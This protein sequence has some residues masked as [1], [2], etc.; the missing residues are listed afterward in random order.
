MSSSEDPNKGKPPKP[1]D[2]PDLGLDSSNTQGSAGFDQQHNPDPTQ[3][4]LEV[5]Q[6]TT[7]ATIT[8]SQPSTTAT[9]AVS[10]DNQAT[11]AVS[12]PSTTATTTMS[13]LTIATSTESQ[14]VMSHT[15]VSS[16]LG[17]TSQSASLLSIAAGALVTV[18]DQVSPVNTTAVPQGP[19][20]RD[21]LATGTP[22]GPRGLL[23]LQPWLH[24]SYLLMSLA[25]TNS[26]LLPRYMRKIRPLK[27]QFC[28]PCS[29]PPGSECR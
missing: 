25:V 1:P 9:I 21:V 28:K 23:T 22:S 27:C 4:T 6:T 3:A 14:S 12:Q 2:D 29:R 24:S 17:D 5:S 15:T 20:T 8:V 10:Q 16:P 26:R 19:V 11:I 18:L 13:L 7:M